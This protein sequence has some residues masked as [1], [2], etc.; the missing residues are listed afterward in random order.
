MS[1]ATL[2]AVSYGTATIDAFKV[3][4]RN[5]DGVVTQLEV[6]G[7]TVKPTDRFWG[8]LCS[9][10]SSLGLSTKLFR[11]FNH[12]EVFDRV[13]SVASEENARM[14]FAIE[15]G[16][17]GGDGGT[18]LAVTNPAKALVEVDKA[19][20]I[21][22]RHAENGLEYKEG[23]IRSTH[24]PPRAAE[25]KIGGDGF[26]NQYVMETPIDGYGNPLTYLS[27]LRMVCTNGMVAYTK[28]F[29]SEIK[30]GNNNNGDEDAMFTI[31]RYLDSFNNEEGFAAIQQRMDSATQS[32]ASLAE[33]F[34]VYQVMNRMAKKRLFREGKAPRIEQ[35]ADAQGQL[36]GGDG[37]SS[38]ELSPSNRLNLRLARAFDSLTGDVTK[39]YGIA[40][41]DALSRKKMRQLPANCTVY[42]LVNFTTELATH[43]TDQHNGRQLQA[44]VGGLI[45]DEYDLE[46]TMSSY[47]DFADW[48]VDN[49][50]L[51][52]A[53][54]N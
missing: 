12:E 29:K 53:G 22:G 44:E 31:E 47:A 46:G 37:A 9:R 30:L 36:I 28:A 25:Y 14:R 42:D 7:R 32:W 48:F 35:M 39:I 52:M 38:D 8:S 20:D 45:R 26:M 50:G 5:E 40:Q 33:C 27:L 17:D 2:P 4:G 24:K 49:D 3:R 23:V 10:Y 1:T 16:G 18:L 15:G 11:L 21:I 41:M 6:D 13:K 43:Y 54:S 34:N 51:G 19:R